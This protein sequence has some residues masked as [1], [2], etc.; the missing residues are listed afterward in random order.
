MSGLID[1]A[2]RKLIDT[3]RT[4]I[5]IHTG[6]APSLFAFEETFRGMAK[7]DWGTK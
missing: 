5:F 6:G 4:V 1:M 7:I 3:D 2:R